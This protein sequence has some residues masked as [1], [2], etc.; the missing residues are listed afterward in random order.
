MEAADDRD[1][2]VPE[3][4]RDIAGLDDQIAGASFRAEKREQ[5]LREQS[6]LPKRVESINR[7][8]AKRLHSFGRIF[9]IGPRQELSFQCGLR[10]RGLMRTGAIP[11]PFRIGN[12]WR[13][14]ADD[15]DQWFES[16]EKSTQ[17]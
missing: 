10:V 15:I 12:Q 1:G 4:C 7:T 16:K 6:S 13:F 5:R 8:V 9:G 11:A 2:S 3:R 17:Q 14:S